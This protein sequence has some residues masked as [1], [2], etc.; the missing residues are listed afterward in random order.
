MAAVHEGVMG[1]DRQ[2]QQ[3]LV[4]LPEELAPGDAGHAVVGVVRHGV[5]D[6][7]ERHPRQGGQEEVV[8]AA[9]LVFKEG[10]L[11]RAFDGVEGLGDELHVVWS[12][13]HLAK[14]EDVGVFGI[15]GKGRV[16]HFVFDDLLVADPPAKLG[17]GVGS[18]RHEPHHR[19]HEGQVLGF[20]FV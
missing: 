11:T 1:L 2:G 7:G 5:G 20:D 4:A 10:R 6:G 13:F 19:G 17:N 3:P 16:H 12:V 9:G 15:D 14:A 18:M 8:V